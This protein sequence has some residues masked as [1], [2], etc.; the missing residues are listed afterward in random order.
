MNHVPEHPYCVA[1]I[2]YMNYLCIFISHVWNLVSL[3]LRPYHDDS[4]H[5]PN[6]TWYLSRTGPDLTCP[7]L[8]LT[9]WQ[10]RVNIEREQVITIH[11]LLWDAIIILV[12]KIV[13]Y[14]LHDDVIKWKHFPR[15]WPFVRGTHRSL[16]KSPHKGQWC[17]TLMFFIWSAPE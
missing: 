7:W 15:Y 3:I 9:S 14:V 13:F 16:V 12:L 10:G 11:G 1:A 4:V 6:R 5:R 8:V 2:N 17:G